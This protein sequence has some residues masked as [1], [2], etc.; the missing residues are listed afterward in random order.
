MKLQS[1]TSLGF[2]TQIIVFYSPLTVNGN[3]SGLCVEIIAFDDL[4]TTTL[5]LWSS[6]IVINLYD[7]SQPANT[8]NNFLYSSAS[9]GALWN[10]SQGAAAI[11]QSLFTVNTTV[12]FADKNITVVFGSTSSFL[13]NYTTIDKS[14]A[15]VA[16]MIIMLLILCACVF[17]FFVQRL[18]RSRKARKVSKEQ[19]S[20]LK[21]AQKSLK[22]ILGKVAAQE[23]KTRIT[24]NFL[25]DYI[26]IINNN[27]LILQSNLSFDKAFGLTPDKLEKGLQIGN[28]FLDLPSTFFLDS[29]YAQEPVITTAYGS[30]GKEEVSIRVCNLKNIGY[31][32]NTTN[33]CPDDL[34][35]DYGDDESYVIIIRKTDNLCKL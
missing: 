28:Y 5:A 9:N 7:N 8:E 35:E 3:N 34:V 6:N 33:L 2:P 30:D 19:I 4:S 11:S 22:Q 25:P 14:A 17:L 12:T 1:F 21:D 23:Q 15:L 31:D 18:K 24:L 10:M 27:G 29:K 32:L 26:A 16:C 13:A 20:V